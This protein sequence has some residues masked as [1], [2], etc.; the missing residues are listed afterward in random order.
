MNRY[1]KM[2]LT[3]LTPVHIGSGVSYNPGQY[4]FVPGYRGEGSIYFLNESKWLKYLYEKKVIDLFAKDLLNKVNAN[5]KKNPFNIYDWL[6]TQK[7]LGSIDKILHELEERS[8]VYPKEPVYLDVNRAKLTNSL[9]DVHPFIRS[10]NGTCYIPGSSIKGVIR[11]ALLVQDIMRHPEK[12]K[13]ELR[14]V[15]NALFARGGRH[16]IERE[17]E[18]TAKDIEKR[19]AYSPKAIEEARVKHKPVDIVNDLFKYVQVSDAVASESLSMGIVQKIDLGIEA[20]ENGGTPKRLPI[21]RECLMP[22]NALYFT[23]GLN[24]AALKQIGF[25]CVEDVLSALNCFAE[26]QYNLQA[27]IYAGSAMQEVDQLSESNCVLGGGTGYLSKTILY[28]LAVSQ[29]KNV[30][31]GRENGI[32]VVRAFMK[33]K[34]DRG[35]HERDRKLSPHTLKLTVYKNKMVLMGLCKVEVE[36]ELC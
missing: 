23:I 35:N 25:S 24:D 2:K 13:E 29:A 15:S 32:H 30:K 19:F 22:D 9:N 8:A 11:T 1:W 3:C 4:I 5:D 34:F 18:R 16:P 20:S 7:S 26:L 12:Y 17:L 28:A 36:Q 21:C 14:S 27:D 33:E 6:S 10:G 31:E